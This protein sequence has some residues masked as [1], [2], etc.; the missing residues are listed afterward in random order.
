[1]ACLNKRAFGTKPDYAKFRK[2]PN[3]SNII[4]KHE[5]KENKML[6]KAKRKL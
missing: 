4:A 1:M 5:I 6:F 3:K 2:S